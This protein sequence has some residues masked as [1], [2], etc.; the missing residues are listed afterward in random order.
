MATITSNSDSSPSLEE[1]TGLAQRRTRKEE[2]ALVEWAEA[3]F[4]K[5]RQ[6]RMAF[7]RQW[8]MNLAF[9][10]GKQ[11]VQWK[12]NQLGSFSRLYE[13][14]VPPWRVRL[15]A[16]K[17]KPIVR[18][19]LAKI[20]KETPQAFI[21]PASGDDKDRI[22]AE[23]AES[24][25]ENLA[26]EL[27]LGKIARRA[28]FWTVICG[29][30]FI[31]D[32]Y[33]PEQKDF[34]GVKGTI[35]VE[36]ISPFHI[37]AADYAEETIDGQPF[38]IHCIAKSPEWVLAMYDKKVEA[39]A[40]A[41]NGM[42]ETKFLSAMGVSNQGKPDAVAVK[43]MWV[44]PGAFKKYPD[45]ARIVWAG[46]QLLE[47]NEKWW[48][49]HNQ[50][51]FQKIDHVPTGRFYGDS[52]IVDLIPLQKE[53]NRTRSQIIESKNRM[54]KPQ[55]LAP[56]GSVDVNKITS[57]PGL[58]IQYQPGF[59]PPQPLPLQS[60]PQYVIEEL[61]RIQRDMD[62]I[63]SQH[64]VTKGRTPPGVNAATAIAYLQEEDDSKLAY[65]VSSLEEAHERLGRH[66]LSHVKQF[67]Q[68]ERMVRVTGDTGA[69]E[70]FVFSGATIGDNTDLRIES[71]SATPRSKAAK[72]AFITELGK[73]GWITPDRALRYLDMA[74]TGRLYE[75]MQ[76]DARHAQRENVKL[77]AGDV[78]VVVNEWDAHEAHIIEHNN[79][80]KSQAFEILTDEGKVLFNMHVTMHQQVLAMSFGS[81]PMVPGDPR[82]QALLAT[83]QQ[84]GGMMPPPGEGAAP[85]PGGGAPIGEQPQGPPQQ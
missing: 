75:E 73:M 11:H 36:P 62:D 77:A 59:T 33:D 55:L 51:P 16:N 37:F 47:V 42:L 31:K 66:L 35:C 82:L 64:E 76:V 68:A 84:A 40:G 1:A 4:Q 46:D 80:R 14:P 58:V 74:E 5:S 69:F 60:I 48:Y 79:F 29:S 7:E 17:I 26:R 28:C 83:Q 20:T 38:L 39:D 2:A 23:A 10:F 15:V 50:Y 30:G 49:E 8:Y 32:W 44:K 6:G 45:G 43:E 12:Q 21:L 27:D 25:Y 24:I 65:T 19:E 52:V 85:E 3:R 72:Q 13:P 57:E 9:Y 54:S 41:Q 78:S 56:K 63:S 22:A 61:D 71:G 18:T 70:A 34:A 53:Y 81:Q 67:W